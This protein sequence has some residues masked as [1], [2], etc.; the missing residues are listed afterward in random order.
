MAKRN[1][2]EYEKGKYTES[3]D[4]PKDKA[5]TKKAHLSAAEKK[6]FEAADRA[7]AA[8][9]KPETMKEDK[10]IDAKNIRKIV[11][12]RHS[13]HEKTESKATEKREDKNKR[14]RPTARH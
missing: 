8:K 1:V 6:K 11:A 10:A 3:K 14:S 13:A 9:K 12:K 2:P 7:H 5:M 4:K